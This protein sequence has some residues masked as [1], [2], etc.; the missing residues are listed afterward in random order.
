[1]DVFTLLWLGWLIYFAIVEGVALFNGSRTGD[2]LS[3][4]VWAWFGIS[5]SKPA[6]AW[7][8]ARRFI[9]LAFMAWLSLHFMSGGWV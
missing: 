5:S 9:L 3:E 7:S 1:M 2:T 6:T 4:H 8:R